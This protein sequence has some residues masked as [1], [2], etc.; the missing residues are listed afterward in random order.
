MTSD[1]RQELK[2]LIERRFDVM[3]SAHRGLMDFL[4]VQFTR[5]DQRFTGDL[6]TIEAMALRILERQGFGRVRQSGVMKD[7]GLTP[8]NLT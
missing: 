1:E 3:E 4:G 6:T 2:E 7:A 5:I 8:E